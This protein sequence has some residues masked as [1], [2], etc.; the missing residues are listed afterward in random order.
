[1]ADVENQQES[2]F[3]VK[4][5]SDLCSQEEDNVASKAQKLDPSSNSKDGEVNGSGVE[6]LA[7]EEKKEGGD[8]EDEDE[9]EEE[10][11]EEVDRKGKGIS[12]EDKGKGKMIEVEESDD[13]DDDDDEDDEDGEEYDESDLSDD[14]LTEVDLDNI[15]PSRTRR[16]SIQP[17]VF[18]SNDRGGGVNEDDDDDSSDD[19]DA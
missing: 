18:I 10:E 8:G 3:P 6:N 12:R 11:E 7:A 4:R 1:M 15:L 2:S 14:P 19:S 16:R 9:E 13:S 17:G 5:K